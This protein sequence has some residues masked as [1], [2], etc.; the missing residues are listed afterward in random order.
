MS[1]EYWSVVVL[2]HLIKKCIGCRELHELKIIKKN[3]F[4]YV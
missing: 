4:L 3:V 1:V 2:K